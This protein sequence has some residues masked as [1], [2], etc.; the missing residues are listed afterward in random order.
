[1]DCPVCQEA[2]ITMELDEVEI[3][4]CA[5]CSGIWLDAGELEQ[6]IGNTEQVEKIMA[7]FKKSGQ[8]EEQTR[9]C[10]VCLRKMQKVNV[11]AS[12]Q[13]VLIDECIKKHG[14]WFDR[15]E[16]LQ[17]IQQGSFDPEN[18]VNKLL[19]QMFSENN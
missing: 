14:L 1:M 12:L 5:R 8:T 4:F 10:P 11:G 7:S 15:G 13:T 6:L 9:K 18:K 2:M 19:E 16:L 17:I 3:D